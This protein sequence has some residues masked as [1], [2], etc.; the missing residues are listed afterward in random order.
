MKRFTLF[1]AILLGLLPGDLTAAEAVLGQG[2]ISCATY[3]GLKVVGMTV[4]L[5]RPERPGSLA[6]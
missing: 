5:R 1:S 3:L 6:L 2:N 4:L